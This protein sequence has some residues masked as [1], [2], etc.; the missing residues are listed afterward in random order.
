MIAAFNRRQTLL[1][2]LNFLTSALAL[3]LAFGFFWYAARM[4]MHG[5]D[6]G[7][8]DSCAPVLI[9]AVLVPLVF[10][11]GVF[12]FRRGGD[13]YAYYESDLFVG[14]DRSTGSGY[15]ADSYVQQVTGPA[16]FV[17]QVI[18]AAPFQFMK[19]I[20]RLRSRI[21][22]SSGLEIEL[23]SLLSA[24]N[25]TPKWHTA[26]TYSDRGENLGYLIRM[27]EIQFSPSKGM[28]RPL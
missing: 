28:V 9:A 27:G 17:T 6:L 23:A 15:T 14:F 19:G 22:E 16:Y 11:Y 7:D 18:L 20:A 5:F 2:V 3:I 21:P 12:E 4:A 13:H 1:A 24:V 10:I 25:V 8:R 26:R